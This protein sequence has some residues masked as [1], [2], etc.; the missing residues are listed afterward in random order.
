MFDFTLFS[1]FFRPE[2][3]QKKQLASQLVQ[4][5]QAE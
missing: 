2:L 1:L 3:P 5:I 4:V